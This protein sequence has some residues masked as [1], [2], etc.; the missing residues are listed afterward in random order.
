MSLVRVVIP[1]YNR[2]K[3]VS[4]AV[5]SVLSQTLADLQVV[6]VDDGSSDDTGAVVGSMAA[7]DPRVVYH[8]KENGGAASAQNAGY[9]IPVRSPTSR[10]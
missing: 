2:S 5:D 1:T 8:R 7:R 6:V 3:L 4:N 10:S 9:G